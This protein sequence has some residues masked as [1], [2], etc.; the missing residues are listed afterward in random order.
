G[1]RLGSRASLFPPARQ[2]NRAG[3]RPGRRSI[4][5]SALLRC[6]GKAYP[7][8]RPRP[9]RLESEDTEFARDYGYKGEGASRDSRGARALQDSGQCP[10]GSNVSPRE[11][12]GLRQQ[13]FRT[14]SEGEAPCPD[15]APPV[16]MCSRAERP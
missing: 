5:L 11:P 3:S 14:K 9:R 16:S 1:E 6:I 7:A 13:R 8:K 10:V 2:R 15:P 4:E 12:Q